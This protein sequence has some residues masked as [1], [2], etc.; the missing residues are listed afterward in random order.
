MQKKSDILITADSQQI[1]Y[2]RY[3]SGN[4]KVI[5]VAHGFFNS[6][7]SV[8]IGKM[9]TQLQKSFDVITF[10][11]RGHGE[12]K[13]LFYWTAK[14]YL[15]LEVILN[16][17]HGHYE[18]IGLV[19]FSLG[20]ATSIITLARGD[21]VDSFIAVSCPTELKKIDYHFWELDIENDIFYNLVGEG[22]KGK[23]VRAGPFWLKKNK[24]INVVGKITAPIFYIHGDADW[25]IKPW[26]SELLYKKTNSEKQIAIIKKGP[27]AEYLL[28]NH[29]QEF[30][31]L[32]SNWFR[33]PL[34]D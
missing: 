8:L 10:D 31:S 18:K 2:N 21:I 7:D 5:I 13:G 30:M 11:F 27:H 29:G 15:D 28:R 14:E 23:G 33:K 1:F 12:S 16:F 3:L 26:H 22:R 9:V 24:P 17:A 32:V 25:I 4:K 6:K 20:A 19:G 34:M